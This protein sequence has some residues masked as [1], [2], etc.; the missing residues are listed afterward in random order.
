MG[1]YSFEGRAPVV[2]PSSFVHPEATLIG[3]VEV[4]EGCYIGPGARLRGDWGRI[5]IGPGCNIQENCVF[6][7][8][9]DEAVILG[10]S[11][12]IGHGAILH[13][14]RL[15]YHVVVGMG[16]VIMDEAVLEDE[17]CIAA[18]ALVSSKVL[19][20]SRKL[21]VGNPG[22][23][24]GEIHNQL[25]QFMTWGTALYQELPAS[26]HDSMR[27]VSREYVFAEG[28]RDPGVTATGSRERLA[29][30]AKGLMK[31]GRVVLKF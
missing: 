28:K 6:H 7:V 19:V 1:F 13:G 25:Y 31:S 15:G 12:H 23:I 30:V 2:A 9:P 21:V 24:V 16:A 17:C 10:P 5:S 11:C 22:K 18:G 27:E 20:P 29:V 4:G 14:P 8:K 3:D 26:C